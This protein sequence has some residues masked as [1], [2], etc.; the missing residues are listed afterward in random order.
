MSKQFDSNMVVPEAIGRSDVKFYDVTE[1]PIRYYGVFREDGMFRRVPIEVAKTVSAGVH[2]M[3]STTAG[4]RLRFMTDSPYVAIAVEYSQFELSCVITNLN[5]VGFDMYADSSFVGAFRPPVDFKGAPLFS[6]LDIPSTLPCEAASKN[7]SDERKMRL[8]TIDMPSYSGVKNMHIGVAESAKISHA[9][10]YSLEKPIV[11]YGSSITNG[12][13]ASRPG[14][15]YEARISRELDVNYINL[16]FGGLCKGEPE[17][18]EYIAGL[19][20]SIFVM[21][22]DHNARTVEYLAQT[23]EPFFKTV[24]KSHPDIPVVFIT[25]PNYSPCK[26]DRLAVVKAT[27][28]NAKANGDENVY[29]IDGNEFFGNDNDFTIDGVHPTDLGFYLMAKR[30][31]EELRPLVE[32]IV[33]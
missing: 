23:H 7:G 17:M 31:G 22:Y 28:D 16:G 2:Q 14:M 24:R 20:M 25:R 21:D 26:N 30:I 15:T 19:D 12:A 5:M 3:C 32:K 27:Y 8:I 1:E 4:G 29:F 11:F 9:P 13:A 33:K 18:A 10:D 6:S